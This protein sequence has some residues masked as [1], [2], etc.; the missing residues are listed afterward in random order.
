MEKN[1]KRH[2]GF[3]KTMDN[4]STGTALGLDRYINQLSLTMY[5]KDFCIYCT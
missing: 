4:A 3:T 5:T 1:K 2:E